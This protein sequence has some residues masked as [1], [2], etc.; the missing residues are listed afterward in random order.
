MNNKEGGGEQK[1]APQK[2]SLCKND[3]TTKIRINFLTVRSEVF[4]YCDFHARRLKEAQHDTN[5]GLL[6]EGIEQ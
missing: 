3:A 1:A 4:D 2:C 5:Q 6:E